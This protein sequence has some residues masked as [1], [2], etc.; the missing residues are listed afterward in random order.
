MGILI[1]VLG[2]LLTGVCYVDCRYVVVGVVV[3]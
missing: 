1:V 2:D 3:V